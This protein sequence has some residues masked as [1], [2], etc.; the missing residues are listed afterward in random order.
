VE[1]KLRPRQ[2][3]LRGGS[4]SY[5]AQRVESKDA[6]LAGATNGFC[7]AANG[8]HRLPTEAEWEYACLAWTS[9]RFSYGD[10]PG[11]T[12]LTNYASYGGNSGQKPHPVGRKLPNPWGLNDMNG[13]LGQ[14]CRDWYATYPG[15]MA[16]DP[17]GPAT[18]SDRVVRGAYYESPAKYCRSADRDSFIPVAI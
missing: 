15:G 4:G 2:R 11:Y 12:N 6:R 3:F 13:N 7:F 18:G 5:C 1:R 8:V 16:L 10:D 14:W 17:R 9:T